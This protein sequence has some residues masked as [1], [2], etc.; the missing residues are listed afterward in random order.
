MTMFKIVDFP[1]DSMVIF[2]SYVSLPEA[3]SQFQILFFFSF[4]VGGFNLP[5]NPS[6]KNYGVKVNGVGMTSHIN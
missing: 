3:T 2:H 1:I 6:V 5:G 4:L